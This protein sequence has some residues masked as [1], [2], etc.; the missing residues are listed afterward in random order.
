MSEEETALRVY[1]SEDRLEVLVDCVVD[2][3]GLDDLVQGI[4]REVAA[5]GIASAPSAAEVKDLLTKAVA[6][7][8]KVAALPIVRGKA[9]VLPIDGKVEWAD[10]FFSMSFAIDDETGRADF[11]Q[12][13]DK[14]LVSEGQQLARVIAPQEG[15]AGVDVF[16]D[17]VEVRKP[18]PARFRIGKGVALNDAKDTASA[19]VDGHL[20]WVSNRL[21]VDNVYRI[22]GSVNLSTGHIAHPGAVIIDQ[23]I[24]AGAK[25]Q[26][27]GD[28][29][30]KGAV[31][32]A[33]IKCGGNLT[34]YGG[35]TGAEGKTIEVAGD[36]AARYIVEAEVQASGEVKV[37]REIR[38]SLLKTQGAISIPSGRIVGGEVTALGGIE[39]GEAGS[40][41]AVPTLL[42]AAVDFRLAD[43]ISRREKEMD[44]RVK[45]AK[46]VREKIAPLQARVKSLSPEQREI[47]TDLSMQ[48]FELE[49]R[50]EV[51]TQE[52]ETLRAESHQ[53]TK[54]EIRIAKA[55]FPET[56]LGIGPERMSVREK[57]PGP[58]RAV[59]DRSRNIVLR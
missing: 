8:P 18:K 1:V 4:L 49:E 33:E 26:A 48:A 19:S 22:A 36:I 32:A 42:V 58:A 57:T 46:K 34:V 13:I 3:Q 54:P 35:I 41:S 21:S 6:Q 50:A 31:E 7:G 47:V 59:V 28:I 11:R 12:R 29:T 10:D 43:A 16:G 30:V 55:V 39:V 20:R 45:T 24:E 51:L 17:P 44:E 15:Q 9:P 56:T 40:E 23:D 25:V 27:D 38:Q 37:Q 53:R 52:I 14:R 5:L 2:V